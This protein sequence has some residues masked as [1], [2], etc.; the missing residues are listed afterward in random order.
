V[1]YI[2]KIHIFAKLAFSRI[3]FIYKVVILFS[4][5]NSVWHLFNIAWQLGQRWKTISQRLI[6]VHS[7]RNVQVWTM[8][9][10]YFLSNS[11]L[12]NTFKSDHNGKRWILGN[13]GFNNLVIY[14]NLFVMSID[15][16][17]LFNTKLKFKQLTSKSIFN[18]NESLRKRSLW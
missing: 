17:S 18:M 1:Y 7:I 16:I 3:N 6:F 9:I 2:H 13:V 8:K 14:I 4:K 12:K 15:F 11:L 5:T 10:F